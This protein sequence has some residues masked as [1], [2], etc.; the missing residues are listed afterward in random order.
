MEFETVA[1]ESNPVQETNLGNGQQIYKD[2]LQAKE[3]FQGKLAIYQAFLAQLKCKG[4]ALISA[5]EMKKADNLAEEVEL[6]EK[7]LL[8]RKANLH[9]TIQG[10]VMEIKGMEAE[11]AYHSSQFNEGGKFDWARSL[12]DES[13]ELENNGELIVAIEK[14][15]QAKGLLRVLLEKVNSEWIQRHQDKAEH[16]ERSSEK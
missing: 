4:P 9:H 15:C 7:Q 16:W 8:E 1:L 11:L 6:A 13:L 3:I 12:L 5:Q 10:L 2:F 14:A